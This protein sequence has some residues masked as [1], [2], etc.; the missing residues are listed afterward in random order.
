MDQ[1]LILELPN[2][3]RSIEHAVEYVTRHCTSCCEYARRLNLNFRVGLT[4]ALSNAMLYGNNSDP[5]K[6]VRVEVA[7]KL[8]EVS[9]RV[10]DQ[11]VGFDPTTVPDP[12]LPANISK[13]GGRGIFLMK[14]LMDEVQFN[15][16]GNSVTLVLRF[17]GEATA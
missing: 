17:E 12:T 9:V 7:I 11:G 16:R 15:D 2:D 3:I 4:E 8:E 13:S 1:E 10:T 5:E 6:S 14:A